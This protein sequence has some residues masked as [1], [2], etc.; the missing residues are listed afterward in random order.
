VNNNPLV[1]NAT[2]TVD[3][4]VFNWQPT[5]YYFPIPLTAINNDPNLAQNNNW[6]GSFDPLQ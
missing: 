5:Y 2:T 3:T 4:K 1:K 6:G